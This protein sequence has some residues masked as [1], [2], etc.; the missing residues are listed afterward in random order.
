MMTLPSFLRSQTERTNAKFALTADGVGDGEGA[1]VV[2]VRLPAR[3][4]VRPIGERAREGRF[5]E[6]GGFGGAEERATWAKSRDGYPPPSSP[7]R[8]WGK[9]TT[10]IR[11]RENCSNNGQWSQTD[12]LTGKF[13]QRQP[14]IHLTMQAEITPL[15]TSF[16]SL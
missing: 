10:T 7:V 6:I 1:A 3:P 12:I 13:L 9:Q 15:L 11:L 8:P 14:K 2:V 5:G 16:N 4:P